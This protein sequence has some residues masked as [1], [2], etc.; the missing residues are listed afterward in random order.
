MQ[1]RILTGRDVESLLPPRLP[2]SH[3]GTYGRLTAVCGSRRFRGAAYLCAMG[4]LRTGV[5]ILCLASTDEV[6]ASVFAKTSECVCETLPANES[7]S[8]AK[9]AEDA[10][11]GLF[12]TSTAL[13]AGCG[14]TD[15]EDT[16]RIVKTV[17]RT[18][19][20]PV[21]LDADGLNVLK[22]APDLLREAISPLVIT[23]H[24][25]EMARLTGRTAEE[26]KADPAQAALDAAKRFGCV[27]VLKDHVTR[28]ASP[29][30]RLTENHT[31]N[32]GLARGGSGDLL[33]GMI[34]SLLAQGTDPYEGA[35]CGVWLHGRAADLCA[36]E[37][38]MTGMLPSDLPEYLCRIFREWNR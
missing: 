1:A 32:A 6:L 11:Q 13:L 22:Y 14:M 8:I 12:R 35:C 16:R 31:G 29:D 37:R 24:I 7:G 28:I 26:I 30:G 5:G 25:G 17:L 18:C 36:A 23:P 4:A 9:E 15:C 20:C 34:A 2:D 19:P 21:L 10:L 38:S 3:K 27:V 33:A